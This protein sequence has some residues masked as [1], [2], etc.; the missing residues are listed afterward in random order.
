FWAT[1]Q[2]NAVYLVESEDR[3]AKLVYLLA[4]PVADHLVDRIS[5]WPG[6]SSLGLSLSGRIQMVRR[7]RGFFRCDGP[8]PEEGTLRV[9][10]PGGF[11]ALSDAEW[12]AK[13]REAVGSEEER[14]RKERLASGRGVLGRKAILRAEPTE[15][16]KTVEPRRKL[17]PHLACL[18]NA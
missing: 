11:E 13:L 4:N 16:P 18:N 12:V 15:S 17:R 1:E 9:E 10:R 14:A 8:M 5:D 7:P 3:L 2:P 6:A